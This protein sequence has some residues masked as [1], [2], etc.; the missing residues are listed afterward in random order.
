MLTKEQ[1]DWI[2]LFERETEFDILW[3]DEVESGEMTF[4]N[5][6]SWN[7]YW[8]ETHTSSIFLKVSH[9]PKS[10]AYWESL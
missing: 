10:E 3:L 9:F 5:M 4:E 2:A 1:Q 7:V 6:A 8:Y